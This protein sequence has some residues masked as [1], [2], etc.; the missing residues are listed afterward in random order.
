MQN[1]KHSIIPSGYFGSSADNI[2]VLE[3]FV[4]PEDVTGQTVQ[5]GGIVQ[6]GIMYN[7]ETDTFAIPE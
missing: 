3:D 7:P 5:E 1:H 6:A 4:A 2:I